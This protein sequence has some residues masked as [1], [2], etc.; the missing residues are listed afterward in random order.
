MNEALHHR[1]ASYLVL[2]ATLWITL[3]MLF[4]KAWAGWSTRSLSLL[5]DALH[6]VVDG[7]STLLSL[8][9]VTSPYRTSGRAVLGYSRREIAATLLLVAGL[10]YAGVSLLGVSLRQLEAMTRPGF[11]FEQTPFPVAINLQLIQLI[12]IVIAVSIC[13]AFFERHEARM[14]ENPALRLNADHVLGDTWLS[15]VLVAGLLGIWQGFVWLDPLLSIVFLV[16]LGRS[17]WQVLSRQ[18]PLLIRQTA[19]APEVLSQMACQVEGV[20]RCR[21]LRAYGIVG[22][23]VYVE[24]HLEVHPDFMSVVRSI[25]ERV[26]GMIRDRYGPVHV[27]IGIDRDR[28]LMDAVSLPDEGPYPDDPYRGGP[29]WN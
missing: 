20:T 16:M 8:I 3:L 18:M 26:E 22:R 28:S 25:A 19:I 10:G 15:F 14:L 24:M 29:G 9:A 1:R 11:P 13:L 21:Y 2:L 6:T 7:F 4:V 23:Y 17:L 27:R 5:V 12:G